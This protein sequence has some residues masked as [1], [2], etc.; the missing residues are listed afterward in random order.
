MTWYVDNIDRVVAELT[1][2]GVEFARYDQ[3]EHDLQGITPR[4]GGGRVAWFRDPD[5][6]RPVVAGATLYIAQWKAGDR[7][8]ASPWPEPRRP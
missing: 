7:C 6:P 4:A 2:V 3:L 1:E 8:P 5:G